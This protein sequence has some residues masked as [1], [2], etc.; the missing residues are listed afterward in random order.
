MGLYGLYA[1]ARNNPAAV[2]NVPESG[3]GAVDPATGLYDGAYFPLSLAANWHLRTTSVAAFDQT[4][5]KLRP[6]LT[7]I[8]GI[9]LTLDDKHFTDSDNASLRSCPNWPIPTNCYLA[10]QGPGIAH[11]YSASYEKGLVSAKLELDYQATPDT[12]VYGSISRGSKAGG[13]NNGF[14]PAGIKPYQ[15]PYPDEAMI[16]YELGEKATLLDRRLRID[17]SAFYYDYYRFQT[18]N[19]EG[20]GGLL[21]D[22]GA[23]SYGAEA[24]LEAAP[25]EH[26]S[27]K[28]GLSWLETK[29][30]DVANSISGSD[31]YI[32]NRQMANAPKWTANG[33]LSYTVPLPSSAAV[34]LNWDWNYRTSR[35]TNNFN[36]P[37]VKLPGYFEHNLD[38]TYQPDA[39]WQ[40]Q[41]FI[42]NIGN[43]QAPTK[44]FQFNDLGYT[45]FIYAEPRVFGGSLSYNW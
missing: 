23:E 13:F 22:H 41:F 29:I 1:T 4:E 3:P 8:A 27:A 45:Q 14:Y 21:T 43:N 28:L 32:A 11:P 38:I 35:Y 19:W 39:D 7:L 16:D 36:D 18:F 17:T 30:R 24:E 2:F 40:V 26:L 10:P 37:S 33:S 20:V 42:R 15:I 44:A 12:L 31:L 5:Y 9:R 25:I 6:D 34:V